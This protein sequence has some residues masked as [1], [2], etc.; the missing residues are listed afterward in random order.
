MRTLGIDYGRSRLGLALSDEAGI[1]ASPLPVHRRRGLEE[2]LAFLA[3]LVSREGIGEVVVGLPVNMDGSLGEMANE[4]LAFAEALTE[5]LGL[6][7]T[8][9]DERLTTAEAERV[10]LE[11]NFSRARRKGLRDSLSAVLILQ[12]YLEKRRNP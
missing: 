12:G 1:L 6:P 3:A 11:A 8:P 2:N 10:L 9:F 4:A 7:V 5:R